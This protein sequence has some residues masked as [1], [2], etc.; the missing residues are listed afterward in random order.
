MKLLDFVKSLV[1]HVTKNT[2]QEDLRVTL[3]ELDTVVLPSFKAA[4]DYL[5]VNKPDNR[6]Y[7]TL[8]SDLKRA[9]NGVKARRRG[10][11][12]ITEVYYRLLNV[13]ENVENVSKKIDAALSQ[14]VVTSG[15]EA[16]KAAYIRS[17]GAISFISR[18]SLDFLSVVYAYEADEKG[19][20]SHLK[21]PVILYVERHIRDFGILLKGYGCDS[22]EFDKTIR[23]IPPVLIGSG[24]TNLAAMVQDSVDR[25]EIEAGLMPG[26][27]YN[28]IYHLRL[29][30]AEWQMKRYEAAKEKKKAL[31]IRLLNY[32][33]QQENNEDTPANLDKEIQYNQKRVDDLDRYLKEVEAELGML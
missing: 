31:E 28:P 23:R 11:D 3:K 6:N 18:F 8:T 24:S 16:D 25:D 4:S 12:P 29:P 21:K 20:E 22:S 5:S 2:I 1:P 33:Y 10:A 26:F 19:G 30:I 13:R 32:Q 17:A 9:L 15:I 27:I 14:D 7:N